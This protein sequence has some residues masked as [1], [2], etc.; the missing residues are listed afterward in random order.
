MP[1]SQNN[2]EWSSYL[3]LTSR[4][5]VLN[6]IASYCHRQVAEAKSRRKLPHYTPNFSNV[7]KF[8]P[9]VSYKGNSQLDLV[10]QG[11]LYL[12][13]MHQLCL[14]CVV[15]PRYHSCSSYDWYIGSISQSHTKSRSTLSSSCSPGVSEHP[16]GHTQSWNMGFWTT[17]CI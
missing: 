13:A 11:A 7:M 1:L 5:R 16:P 2:T 12:N 17:T 14:C 3:A 8:S 6:L 9:F 15:S 4:I 10:H